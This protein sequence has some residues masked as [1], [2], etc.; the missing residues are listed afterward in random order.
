MFASVLEIV[1]VLEIV[2][3][4]E[5]KGDP[6]KDLLVEVFRDGYLKAEYCFEDI[7]KS[8]VC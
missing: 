4:T 5:G 8:A 6:E 1:N 2:T 7:R 3:V